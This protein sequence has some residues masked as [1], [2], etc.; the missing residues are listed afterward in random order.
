MLSRHILPLS[1]AVLRFYQDQYEVHDGIFFHAQKNRL[2]VSR[3]SHQIVS[4]FCIEWPPSHL[5]VNIEKK[6]DL[7]NRPSRTRLSEFR[8]T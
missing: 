8:V 3:I 1:F 4:A 7:I 2:K 5:T 6:Y